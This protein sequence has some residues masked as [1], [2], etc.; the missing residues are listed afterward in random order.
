MKV[1]LPTALGGGETGGRRDGDA[2][3]SSS[4]LVTERW[5]ASMPS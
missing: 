4:T 5:S 1:A 3:G 2:G